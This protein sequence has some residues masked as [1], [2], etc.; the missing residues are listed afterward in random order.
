MRCAL[1]SNADFNLMNKLSSRT[2]PVHYCGEALSHF[3][4]KNR[5]IALNIQLLV[6]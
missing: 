6:N 4:F 2:M 5:A 1:H 3:F